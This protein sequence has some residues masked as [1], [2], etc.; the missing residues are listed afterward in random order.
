ML[1]M[2]AM[3]RRRSY[4]FDARSVMLF[5]ALS[6]GAV[7]ALHAQTGSPG[8]TMSPADKTAP[9]SRISNE[10]VPG[11]TGRTSTPAT[12]AA[13]DRAD[14]N[15][16]GQLSLQEAAQLPAIGQR[17]TELDADRN[18]TLSRAEFEKGAN[19]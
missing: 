9:A 13:F 2:N 8:G 10:P 1:S 19:S 14:T 5:A 6:L 18:G 12:T 3:Q 15:R 17:F 16:D 11:T 7:A 4:P